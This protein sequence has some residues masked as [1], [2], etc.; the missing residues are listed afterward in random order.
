[1]VGMI[2]IG[3]AGWHYPDWYGTVYPPQP[4]K[5]FSELAYIADYFSI[6]E[7]NATFYRFPTKPMVARWV[8]QVAHKTD[9]LF[10]VKLHQQF[11][12]ER[13]MIDQKQVQVFIDP[14]Q[15]M[16]EKNKLAT[17]LVQFPWSY[18]KTTESLRYLD[19]LCQAFK[20]LP[21]HFEFRHASWIGEQTFDF[22]RERR[23]GI[24]NIDQPVIGQS[25]PPLAECTSPIAYVRLHGRNY[26]NWFREGAGRDARYDYLYSPKELEEWATRIQHLA[27]KAEKTLVIFNNHFKG[28]A[29]INTLQLMSMLSKKPIK[30]PPTLL[31]AYPNLRTI[32]QSPEGQGHFDF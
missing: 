6:V 19:D 1:M 26:Q 21:L 20:N 2:L 22:L 29:V 7:I 30:V 11:T 12:H 18:K 15:P 5:D 3:F 28:Q 27:Q 10:V 31:Q 13:A 23:V 4:G 8:T 9:F 24:V 32:S 14:L 17:I 25:I 16:V